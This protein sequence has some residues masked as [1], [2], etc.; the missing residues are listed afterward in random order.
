VSSDEI[1]GKEGDYG[2]GNKVPGAQSFYELMPKCHGGNHTLIRES[3]PGNS[4]RNRGRWRDWRNYP[5]CE[6]R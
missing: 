6:V 1:E 5:R 2:K 3:A 4:K